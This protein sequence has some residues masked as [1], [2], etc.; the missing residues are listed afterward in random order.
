MQIKILLLKIGTYDSLRPDSVD[1]ITVTKAL[2][3]CIYT[4]PIKT[5]FCVK[6]TMARVGVRLETHAAIQGEENSR[7]EKNQKKVNVWIYGPSVGAKRGARPH[8]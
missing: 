5:F 7:K 4:S 6:T 1:L 2:K 8:E 3:T